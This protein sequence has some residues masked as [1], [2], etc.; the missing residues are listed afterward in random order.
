MKK[1]WIIAALFAFALSFLAPVEAQDN[2][3][4]DS[5]SEREV[6]QQLERW[7]TALKV[8]DLAALDRIIAD[9]FHIVVADGRLLNKEQDLEPLKSGDLKFDSVSTEDVK[10]FIH[11]D[12]AVVTGIGVFQINYQGLASGFRERFFDV[13]QKRK[14]QWQV[15]ASRS[16][17]ATK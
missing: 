12:M 17:P 16:T 1:N 14:K 5:R 4:N 2:K 9:D 8:K 6:L 13:Y 15:V 3:S 11:G 10:V 7:V